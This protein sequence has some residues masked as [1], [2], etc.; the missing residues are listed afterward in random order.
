LHW[1]S[2]PGELYAGQYI[3]SDE[4]LFR[5]A[6]LVVVA[7]VISTRDA[8]QDPVE[9]FEVAAPGAIDV[10]TTLSVIHIFKGD[11]GSKSIVLHH[12]R[13]ELED[14]FIGP[15]LTGPRF[16]SFD[17]RQERWFQF[18]L[19][20]EATGR[21]APVSGQDDPEWSVRTF[22]QTTRLLS[23]SFALD[24]FPPDDFERGHTV[25]TAYVSNYEIGSENDIYS[26]AL[27]GG[28]TEDFEAPKKAAQWIELLRPLQEPHSLPDSPNRIVTIRYLDGENRVEKRFPTDRVPWA[29]HDVLQKMGALRNV[30]GSRYDRLTFV[31]PPAK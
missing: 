13:P 24:D 20:R 30:K 5:R 9:P 22:S 4:A 17:P 31:E 1:L 25:H 6:D 27:Q 23:I 19:T 18:Y 3:W 21:F 12:L 2:G 7:S 29:V 14:K 10:E 26:W 28:S 16:V 8:L 15:R 11:P